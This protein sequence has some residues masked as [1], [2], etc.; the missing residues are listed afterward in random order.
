MGRMV[1]GMGAEVLSRIEG[2]HPHLQPH[3]GD[4]T[5]CTAAGLR[6]TREAF[7]HH[8]PRSRGKRGR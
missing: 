2:L 6:Y 7:L 1:V 5:L 3:P 4:Q 8:Q